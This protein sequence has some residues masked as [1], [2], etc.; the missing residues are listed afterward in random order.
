[1][2]DEVKKKSKSPSLRIIKVLEYK[3]AYIL[4]Q[5]ITR[6]S[7]FQVVVFYKNNFYQA[8]EIIKPDKTQ[9]DFSVDDLAKAGSYMVDVGFQIVDA[10]QE[11]P[12]KNAKGE[13]LN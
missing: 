3:G 9:K 10:L 2:A 5:Q 6:A 7:V 13:T 12:E 8:H 4:V 1:M 11:A